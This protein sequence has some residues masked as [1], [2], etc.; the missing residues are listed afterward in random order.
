MPYNASQKRILHAAL[1]VIANHSISGT[2]MH[3]IASEAGMSSANLHYH[4]KTKEELL[5]ALMQ[6]LGRIFSE[7]RYTAL[8]DCQDTL[9]DHLRALFQ[10]KR[11]QILL[12]PE[13][14][15]VQLDFWVLGQSDE[16]IRLKFQRPIRDWRNHLI[17]IL[18]HFRPAITQQRAELIAHSMVSMMLGG[19][20]QYLGDPSFDLDAY[21]DLCLDQTLN[22]INQSQPVVN[23]TAS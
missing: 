22:S 20:M 14:D 4:F 8:E 3:L 1:I 6:D 7:K 2:R 13:Y 23:D 10:Q 12:E 15:Q 21:F 9:E 5:T 11:D 16:E 18:R 17:S 19:A